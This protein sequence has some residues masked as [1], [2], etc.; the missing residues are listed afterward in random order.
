MLG[1]HEKKKAIFLIK[2]RSKIGKTNSSEDHEIKS[3]SS[4]KI[5]Q[6]LFTSTFYKQLDSTK[7]ILKGKISIDFANFRLGSTDSSKNLPAPVPL[8]RYSK[9]ENK[10]LPSEEKYELDDLLLNESLI[11]RKNEKLLRTF[12]SVIIR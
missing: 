5:N 8:H 7:S 2:S 10:M 9:S 3:S 1:N 6:K 12:V 4:P 11:S